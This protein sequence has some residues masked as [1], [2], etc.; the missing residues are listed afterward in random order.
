MKPGL[1]FVLTGIWPMALQKSQAVRK[2]SSLVLSPGDIST[3]FM[4]CAGRQKCMPTKRSARPE[5]AAISVIESVDVLD[6]KIVCGGQTLSSSPHSACL[7]FRSSNTASITMSHCA[8]SAM[9][10]VPE[11]PDMIWSTSACVSFLRS[12]DFAKNPSVCLRARS[13]ASARVS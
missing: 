8:S 13:S 5:P 12:T 9:S 10:V 2:E 6:A 11:R 3:S 1:S 4:S 7:A